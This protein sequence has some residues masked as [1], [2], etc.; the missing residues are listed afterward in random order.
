MNQ[1]HT[2]VS[3]VWFS[4]PVILDNVLKLYD[5]LQFLTNIVT[6]QCLLIHRARI[7]RL[8]SGSTS[9]RLQGSA[10]SYSMGSK[11]W[12]VPG[13]ASSYSVEAARVTQSASLYSMSSGSSCMSGISNIS[14]CSGTSGTSGMSSSSS[15]SGT[16]G[17]SASSSSQHH[18]HHHHKH[19]SNGTCS[20]GCLGAIPRNPAYQHHHKKGQYYSK[21][22]QADSHKTLCS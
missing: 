5:S 8:T 21:V 3:R 2:G 12:S 14:S 22:I 1:L 11:S 13:S 6:N 7:N 10:S 4:L 9:W 17:D 19:C 15:T 18:Q 20:N 16:G